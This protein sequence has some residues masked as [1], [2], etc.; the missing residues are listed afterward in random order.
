[1]QENQINLQD[2]MNVPEVKAAA[3]YGVDIQMLLS[4]LNRSVSERI[5]RHQIALDAVQKLRR[6]KFL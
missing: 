6:A 1:M 5:R 2:A 3:E 4:N